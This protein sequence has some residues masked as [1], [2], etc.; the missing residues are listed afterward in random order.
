[1]T[2]SYP[3]ATQDIRESFFLKTLPIRITLYKR[4]RI[5]KR[6][7]LSSEMHPESQKFSI[8]KTEMNCLCLSK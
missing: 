6:K 1:M 3:A 8:L 7:I 5:P 2:E 4:L